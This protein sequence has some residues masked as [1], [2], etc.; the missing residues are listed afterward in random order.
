MKYRFLSLIILISTEISAQEFLI[1]NKINK[2]I[3]L[4]LK[5]SNYQKKEDGLGYLVVEIDSIRKVY[6]Q[7]DAKALKK[8]ILNTE[9]E[10][11]TLLIH[12]RYQSHFIRLN[13]PGGY[14]TYKGH[15][16]FFYSGSEGAYGIE[17]GNEF[18]E[19]NQDF[20][21]DRF[22][23]FSPTYRIKYRNE[24]YHIERINRPANT[25]YLIPRPN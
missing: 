23:T 11:F 25:K 22:S 19:K 7:S 9:L 20:F 5:E 16:I 3:D 4:F 8:S 12:P 14:K 21:R 2:A 6:K 15:L 1:N 18:F 17:L 24:S 10:S 13:P